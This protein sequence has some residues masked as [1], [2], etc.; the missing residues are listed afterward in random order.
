MEVVPYFLW[1]RLYTRSDL[2]TFRLPVE[3]AVRERFGSC[4]SLQDSLHL[5]FPDSSSNGDGPQAAAAAA[6]MAPSDVVSLVQRALQPEMSRRMEARQRMDD[7]AV[8]SA[9]LADGGGSESGDERASNG[10]Q[11]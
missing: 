7:A 5:V 10:D 4:S 3:N 6:A 1:K 11:P 8:R 9:I 2:H